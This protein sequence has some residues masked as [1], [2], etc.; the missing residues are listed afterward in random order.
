MPQF[1]ADA[2]FPVSFLEVGMHG[3]IVDYARLQDALIQYKFT[4]WRLDY[5]YPATIAVIVTAVSIAAS[6][7]ASLVPA[8]SLKTTNLSRALPYE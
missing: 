2:P 5:S 6:V 1:V 4:G 3:L 8:Q 7:M